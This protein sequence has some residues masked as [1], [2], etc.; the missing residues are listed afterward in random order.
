MQS[1]IH[2]VMQ[3]TEM[4]PDPGASPVAFE[5]APPGVDR[6]KKIFL[7]FGIFS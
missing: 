1:S 2:N 7:F 5:I 6:A 3:D 4:R